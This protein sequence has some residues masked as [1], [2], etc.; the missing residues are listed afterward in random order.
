M[1]PLLSVAII[2]KNEERNL[3]RTLA[4]VQFA[5]EIVVLDSASTDR[6]VE[7][8]REFNARV[9]DEPWRGFAGSKNSAIAK[10]TGTWILSLDADEE[11]SPE[12]QRQIRL[13]LPSNPP[14]DAFY[15]RRRNLFLG[16]WIKHG[17]FYPDPKLR[18]FR[19]SA[20]S[21]SSTP[22]F[23]DRPVHETITFDG[24]AS[25][26]DYDLI[27]HA[28]PTLETYI[29]H[30]DRYSTLGCELLV[31]AGRTS[32]SWPA[33]LANILI[34]PE[35]TFL[36]NYIVRLGFL[37]GREGLLLHLYHA[38]YTSW[39]YAKAWQTTLAAKP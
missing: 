35:A 29:E 16:R 39:K 12:L 23:E 24:E 22:Q 6:T 25:T 11:L 34:A 4:S 9:F 38:T 2:T 7:I 27:H 36:W 32:R 18:L 10:C 17:G 26:L 37:D 31:S 3:A 19:R 30:M 14:T 13:L 15:I 5:D 1:P 21:F 33:F 20:A 8:A 28:Y